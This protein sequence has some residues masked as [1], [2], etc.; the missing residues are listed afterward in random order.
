[1]GFSFRMFFRM[2]RFHWCLIGAGML[3]L[4]AATGA[5]ARQPAAVPDAHDARHAI[6]WAGTYMGTLPAASGTGYRTVLVLREPGRYTLLQDIEYRGRPLA[7]TAQGRFRWDRSGS[8]IT[9]DDEGDGQRFFVSEGF[10]AL[11]GDAP[12]AP[13]M[14]ADYQLAKMLSYP[15]RDQELLVDARSLRAGEPKPGWV[16]F[17]G[18]WNMRHPTQAG[19]KSLAARFQLDCAARAYRMSTV[20]YYSQPYRRGELIDSTSRNDHDIPVTRQD[21]VMTA[22]LRDHCPR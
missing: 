21:R 6:D 11:H 12:P 19:H 18:V 2:T 22:V 4:A 14:A 3:A 7:F 16:S 8:V 17:D 13:S 5:Q 9:L 10:V 1:M 20:A 15:S